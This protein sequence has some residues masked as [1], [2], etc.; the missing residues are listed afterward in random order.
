MTKVEA[1]CFLLSLLIA[2]LLL[3]GVDAMFCV[4]SIMV[5]IIVTIC[6]MFYSKRKES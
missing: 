5:L 2:L 1:T 4:N 3:I 6:D